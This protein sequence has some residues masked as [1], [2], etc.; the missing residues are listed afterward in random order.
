MLLLNAH[1][2][3]QDKND[4]TQY[5]FHKELEHVFGQFPKCCMKFMLEDFSTTVWREDIFKPTV[6]NESLHEIINNNGVTVL[7]FAT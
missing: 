1:A 4:D 2:P 5:N 3:T 6:R 7:K